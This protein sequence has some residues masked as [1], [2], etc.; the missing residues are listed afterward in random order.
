MNMTS[1]LQPLHHSIT[2]L[3]KKAY[4]QYMIGELMTAMKASDNIM[5][6]AKKVT[7]FN[8]VLKNK[9]AWDTLPEA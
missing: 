2:T 1:R 5:E 7:I 6:L 9:A 4:I 8:A 3:V